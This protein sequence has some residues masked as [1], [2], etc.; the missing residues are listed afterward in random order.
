MELLSLLGDE[1]TSD[2]LGVIEEI[3]PTGDLYVLRQLQA[4]PELVRQFEQTP[5]LE[6]CLDK[7]ASTLEQNALYRELYSVVKYGH[8]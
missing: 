7:L 5:G 2:H 1:P 4:K 3:A 8:P 6:I